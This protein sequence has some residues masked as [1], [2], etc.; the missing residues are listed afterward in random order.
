MVWSAL[1][2]ISEVAAGWNLSISDSDI[3]I[4][5]AASCGGR[6]GVSEVT[7]TAPFMSNLPGIG[8]ITLSASGCYPNNR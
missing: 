4:N 2:Y 6:A 5:T 7:L 3:T 8:T 1:T